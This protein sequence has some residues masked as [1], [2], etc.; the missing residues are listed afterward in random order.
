MAKEIYFYLP[1]GTLNDATKFYCDLIQRGFEATG[2]NVIRVENKKDL[3]P[4]SSLLT[5]R[6]ADQKGLSKNNF[7][8]VN[9]YQG[10]GPEEYRLLNNYNVKSY[11]VSKILEYLERRSLKNSKLC[12]F[13]SEKMQEFYEKKYSLNLR[14]KSLIIPCYNIPL[15]KEFFKDNERFNSTELKFVYAGGLF[16]WQCIIETLL[17]FK[18]IHSL[19]PQ[20]ELT[21][22]TGDNLEAERL[23]KKYDVKNVKIGYV[24]LSDLQNELSKY[25]YGFLLRKD[26][27]INNVSTPTKMNSYLAAGLIPIYSPVIDSFEKNIKLDKFELKFKVDSDFKVIAKN[28]VEF[29]KKGYSKK[30]LLSTY[31]RIF[32]NFYNDQK[33]VDNI[34]MFLSSKNG[35]I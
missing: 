30:D 29:H 10:I 14:D 11:F 1:A 19:M 23:I 16:A 28:I 20:A 34:K 5:I 2:I 22:L 27:P 35:T 32:E 33:Y 24:K 8:L 15:E 17:L 7:N 26:D 21:I 6:P 12:F 18:E 13:V 25:T 9:W 31:E 4:G 3:I